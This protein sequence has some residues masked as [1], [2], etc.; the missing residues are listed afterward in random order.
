MG[1]TYIIQFWDAAVGEELRCELE[2]HNMLDQY[3]VAVMKDGKAVGHLPKKRP[4]ACSLFIRRGGVVR[5]SYWRLKILSRPASRGLGD[6][7]LDSVPG[8]TSG[9]Q[10]TTETNTIGAISMYKL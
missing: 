1:I 9:N 8:R 5:C 6:S 4:R 3:M 10:E 2:T 7:L